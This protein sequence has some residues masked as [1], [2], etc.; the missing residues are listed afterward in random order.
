[1]RR[2][3]LRYVAV[4]ALSALAVTACSSS[5]KVSSTTTPTPGGSVTSTT[6]GYVTMPTTGSTTASTSRPG[7]TSGAVPT[8]SI[9]TTTLGKLLVDGK[10]LT[11]YIWDNDKTAGKSSCAGSCAT[12]WPPVPVTGTPT[13]GAGVAASLFSVIT[14]TDGTKQ[15]AVNGKPLYTFASDKKAKD[16]TG[17]GIG[18]FHV[19]QPNGKK[20]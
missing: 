12:I 20:Y 16:V 15:L 4:A 6:T 10:G 5:S 14:R 7:T 11:L 17:Q 13:Y 2:S 3:S 8:V 18:G 9:E 19:V 1:M